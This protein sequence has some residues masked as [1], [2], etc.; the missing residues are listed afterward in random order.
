MDRFEE[1]MKLISERRFGNAIP[2][3][4][5]LLSKDQNNTDLLYNLG[6][7]YTEIGKPDAAIQRLSRIIEAHNDNSDVHVAL[8]YAYL[9]LGNQ[10]KGKESFLNALEIDGNNP[11]ALRNLGG[12]YGKEGDYEKGLRC[13]NKTLEINAHDINAAYG[14]GLLYFRMGDF[15]NA[16]GFLNKVIHIDKKSPLAG[17]AR[18]LQRE[19]AVLNGKPKG[20][21][22][23][24][25]FYCMEALRLF[26]DKPLDEIG[27]ISFEIAMKG[28]ALDIND[29]S[30]THAVSSLSGRF[31][32]LQ[33]VS[34]M[35]VGYR[36]V[37]PEMD[38]GL[39]L[40]EEYQM[41]LRLTSL[42]ASH[43]VRIN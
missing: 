41:A 23:D 19:I 3:L 34:Y 31:T 5:E 7:C 42:K 36:K 32:G 9:R 24:A 8:G 16:D 25:M 15:K 29:P 2:V 26:K 35:Y 14:L 18:D 40:S 11:Y 43:G 37:A 39:D 21:R 30:K 4:E 13:L 27:Q 12:L 1:A 17:A 6:M 10:S 20:F 38:V 33:L 22:I 28:C